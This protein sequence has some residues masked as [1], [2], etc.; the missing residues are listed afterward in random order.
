M[1]LNRLT[2]PQIDNF[3]NQRIDGKSARLSDGMGLWLNVTIKQSRQFRFDYLR[4]NS[5]SKNFPNGKRNTISIGN[6]PLISLIDARKQRDQ[7]KLLLDKGVD[8]SK[9]KKSKKRINTLEKS[10]DASF[11]EVITSLNEASLLFSRVFI[12]FL[13]FFHLDGS[14]PLSSNNLN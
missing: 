12:L 10:S 7:F 3:I 1:F 4:P 9:W 5:K 2:V 13:D 8:P 6:Y 11:K 14:T